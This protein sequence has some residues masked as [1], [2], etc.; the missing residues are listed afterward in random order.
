MIVDPALAAAL[1]HWCYSADYF[2]EKMETNPVR[3]SRRPE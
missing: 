2:R 1:R 3:A